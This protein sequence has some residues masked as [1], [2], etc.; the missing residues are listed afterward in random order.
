MPKIAATVGVLPN[1]SSSFHR[2]GD[3]NFIND[4]QGSTGRPN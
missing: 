1:M 4:A 2:F 3:D